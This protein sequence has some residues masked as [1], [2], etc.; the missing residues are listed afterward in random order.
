MTSDRYILKF[1]IPVPADPAV[2]QA[3]LDLGWYELP[4]AFDEPPYLKWSHGRGSP[5]HPGKDQDGD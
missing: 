1:E 3:Y 4:G 5:K 2:R